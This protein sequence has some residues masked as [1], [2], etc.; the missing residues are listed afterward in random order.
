MQVNAVQVNDQRWL[1]IRNIVLA[2]AAAIVVVVIVW[3]DVASAVW[4]E[5]VILSG[6]AAGLVTFLLTVMVLDK[7]LARS[8]ARRWAP[9]NRLALTEFLHALAD[10]ERSEITRGLVVPRTLAE[11][12]T[13]PHDPGYVEALDDLRENVHRE[14]GALTDL[15]GRWAP[16]LASSGDNETVLLHVADLALAFDVIRDT[17]LEAENRRDETSHLTLCDEVRRA[18][19]RLGMLVDELRSG[20]AAPQYAVAVDLSAPATASADR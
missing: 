13:A 7:V 11:P 10:D 9:V 4:Q 17:S 8:T 12:A 16:F 3:L 14:R 2:L 20:L 5:V 19:V 6:L 18:N 15:L 1:R